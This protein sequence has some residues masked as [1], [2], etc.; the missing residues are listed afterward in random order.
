MPDRS[1][2]RQVSLWMG[3]LLSFV[4]AG[5]VWAVTLTAVPSTVAPGGMVTVQV[6]GGPGDPRDCLTDYPAGVPHLPANRSDKPS[7]AIIARTDP[8]EQESVVLCDVTI[9]AE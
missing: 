2:I 4:L 7:S 5:P 6:A 9:M 1:R 3:V 8:N